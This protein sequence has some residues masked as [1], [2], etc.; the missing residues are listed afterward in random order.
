MKVEH[1]HDHEKKH[2]INIFLRETGGSHGIGWMIDWDRV[3]ELRSEVGE[4][5][6]AE[7]VEM[8]FEEIEGA[9]E[10]LFGSAPDAV[11]EEL[12]FIK[13]SALNIGLIGVSDLC[14]SAETKLRQ[15]PAPHVELRAIHAAFGKSKAE[16]ASA[17]VR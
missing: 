7:V 12:H 10:R 3:K 13:G 16:L 6:F 11:G 17:A 9:L 2:P 8:F 4:E 5:D 15:A 1:F 14:R